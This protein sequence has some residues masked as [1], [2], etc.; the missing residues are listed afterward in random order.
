VGKIQDK[1]HLEAAQM[2]FM[3]FLCGVTNREQVR[4]E[5]IRRQIGEVIF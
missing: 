1:T 5:N 3:R 2:N 4:S